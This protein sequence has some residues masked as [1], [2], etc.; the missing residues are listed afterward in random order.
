MTALLDGLHVSLLTGPYPPAFFLERSAM[1]SI[2]LHI[3]PTLLSPTNS[4]PSLFYLLWKKLEGTLALDGVSNPWLPW[5]GAGQ[6]RPTEGAW[7]TQVH[8]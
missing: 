5:S 1:E 3:R 2:L 7:C 4:R 6:D 8:E